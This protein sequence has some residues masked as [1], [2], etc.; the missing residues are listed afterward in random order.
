MSTNSAHEETPI[1]DPTK[2][3]MVTRSQFSMLAWDGY[4]EVGGSVKQWAWHP[5]H[6]VLLLQTC[7]D[8][9]E[10]SF[11]DICEI[12]F[13][14]MQWPVPS[15]RY[16]IVTRLRPHYRRLIVLD[17][18]I[19]QYLVSNAKGHLYRPLGHEGK[20]P[21][22]RQVRPKSR[23]WSADEDMKVL[24]LFLDYQDEYSKDKH[25]FFKQ[26]LRSRSKETTGRS[27][28]RFMG[29]YSH[30]LDHQS[31]Y[32]LGSGYDAFLRSKIEEIEARQA[33]EQKAKEAEKAMEEPE[34]VAIGAAVNAAM[35]G[36][37]KAA[38]LAKIDRLKLGASGQDDLVREPRDAV[39]EL[40]TSD[41]P[42][43]SIDP[44]SVRGLE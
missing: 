5:E 33:A 13:S 7:H 16:M 41:A 17:P 3:Q 28:K 18:E 1:T 35:I 34:E 24:Q 32:E 21:P 9:V 42:R 4:Q 12:I 6:D 23:P 10:A 36:P 40:D 2:R 31:R 43:R 27:Y 19:C 8:N 37:Y 25:R 26:W 11:T 30:L 29:R 38:I 15:D 20:L 39:E 22:E 44:G 14:K